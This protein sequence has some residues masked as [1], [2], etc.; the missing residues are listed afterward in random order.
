MARYF[1][2]CYSLPPATLSAP[3]QHRSASPSSRQP[4]AASLPAIF[5]ANIATGVS[6]PTSVLVAILK[7]Q[8]QLD[9]S[10][11]KIL[12]MLSVA[13]FEKSPILQAF[14]NFDAPLPAHNS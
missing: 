13:I 2:P 9:L 5:S 8:L 12:Q 14:L 11:Y 10:L 7:K 4:W 1:R 3:V 6:M